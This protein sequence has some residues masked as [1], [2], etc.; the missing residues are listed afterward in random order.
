MTKTNFSP[1]RMFARLPLAMPGSLCAAWLGLA[2]I[3]AGCQATAPT[4]TFPTLAADGSAAA[5]PAPA[6]PP[7]PNAPVQP[8]P[9]LTVPPAKVT[10]PAP[11]PAR[12]AAGASAFRLREGDVVKVS[13]PSA[14]SLD[15]TDTIRRDG[16]ITLSIGEVKA[17]GFTPEEFQADLR[18][19]YKKEL[20]NNEVLVGIVS[21]TFSVFING[22]VLRPGK[23]SSERPMSALDA[24]SEAGGFD[25]IK[26]DKKKVRV[27]RTV[28][29]KI[30][31]TVLN[32]DA[33]LRGKDSTRYMLEPGDIL[34]V[35]ERWIIL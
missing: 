26:A 18:E 12:P 31:I 4:G 19:R 15:K 28:D 29:G 21:S 25:P 30:K 14:P 16:M 27:L 8:P 20:V 10:A 13:F 22:C 11:T 17:V 7:A 35:P 23:I 32:L 34:E 6:M 33:V 5:A 2:L 1:L 3:L 9:T 24:I